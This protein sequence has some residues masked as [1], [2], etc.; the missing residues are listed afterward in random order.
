MITKGMT[1]KTHSPETK[2]KMV[3]A[4]RKPVALETEGLS[5]AQVGL[6]YEMRDAYALNPDIFESV[7]DA[8]VIIE[9]LESDEDPKEI[10]KL[11]TPLFLAKWRVVRAKIDIKRV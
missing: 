8:K 9:D 4:K 5:F 3:E 7:T 2:A 11:L 6:M 10:Q 1:G